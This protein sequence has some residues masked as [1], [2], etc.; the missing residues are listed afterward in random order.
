M[1]IGISNTYV[2]LLKNLPKKLDKRKYE[3]ILFILA[4]EPDKKF[5]GR[6]RIQLSKD[7]FNLSSKI[8]I[9]GMKIWVERWRYL[10]ENKEYIKIFR[11]FRRKY[12][13][14]LKFRREVNKIVT[15]NRVYMDRDDLTKRKDYVLA[16]LA[17]INYLSSKGITKIGPKEQEGVFDELAHKFPIVDE[18]KTETF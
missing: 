16:E 8:K 14:N 6:E 13:L 10:S 18:V 17:S 1:G 7:L 15:K 5:N 12:F 3:S 9:D 2:K 4:D 11:K